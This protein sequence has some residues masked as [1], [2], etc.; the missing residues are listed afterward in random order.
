M[1]TTD[2]SERPGRLPDSSRPAIRE[3]QSSSPAGARGRPRDRMPHFGVIH[4]RF[5]VL[6]NDHLRYLLAGKE[7]CEHLVVGITNP[8]P[9]LIREES[10]DPRRHLPLTNPLT[11]FERQWIVREALEEAGVPPSDFTIVPFPINLPK[12]YFYYVPREAT[13]FLTIYD[14]WG[15][16]KLERFKEIGLQTE[17]LWERSPQEKGLTGEEIRERILTQ[18]PWERLVPP[19]THQYLRLW[20]IPARIRSLQAPAGDGG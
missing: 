17:V 4:G 10:S 3:K 13:Y 16:R 2:G 14:D 7:R 18:E 5:Q 9:T 8:D 11:Y 6:H 15:R 12:L 1:E 20:R 19:S